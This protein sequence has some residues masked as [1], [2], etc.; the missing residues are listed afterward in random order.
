M[1]ELTSNQMQ[2]MTAD[3][4]QQHL[5]DVDRNIAR[6]AAYQQ[7]VHD[8]IEAKRKTEGLAAKLMKMSP[9]ER[10]AL[11]QMLVPEGVASEENVSKV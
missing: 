10:Q 9:A 8:T 5:Y 3:D 7:E 4:L 6:M 11:A 2:G 1:R